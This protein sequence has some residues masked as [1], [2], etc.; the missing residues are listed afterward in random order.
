[1]FSIN[2]WKVLVYFVETRHGREK[3]NTKSNPNLDVTHAKLA[4][5]FNECGLQICKHWNENPVDVFLFWEL[6]SLSL[7]F[8]IPESVSDLYIP[9]ICPNISCS[10]IDRSIVGIHRSLTD[11]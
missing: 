6:R 4:L 11:T 3:L 1:M 7:N 8:H 10:R 9:R 2:F 5:V